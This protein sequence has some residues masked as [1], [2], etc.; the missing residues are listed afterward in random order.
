MWVIKDGQKRLRLLQWH[1][2]IIDDRSMQAIAK[3]YGLPGPMNEDWEVWDFV[4]P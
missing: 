4:G 2:N 1:D 3:M